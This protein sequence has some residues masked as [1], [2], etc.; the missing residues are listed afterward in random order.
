MK[1]Y[2]V[3]EKLPPCGA[4]VRVK[5][6]HIVETDAV[7][8]GVDWVST[9]GQVFKPGAVTEWSR[10]NPVVEAYRQMVNEEQEKK[11]LSEKIAYDA[12]RSDI[13]INCISPIVVRRNPKLRLWYDINDVPVDDKES[14]ADSVRYLDLLG[15]LVRH[16]MKSN[17]VMILDREAS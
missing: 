13:E 5:A 4:V 10:L 14:I 2:M 11:A 8:D 3:T 6:G 1:T 17:L 15:K 9:N 7:F 16:P 12:A